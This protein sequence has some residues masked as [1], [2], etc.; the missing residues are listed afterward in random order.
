MMKTE[1]EL[2][3]DQEITGNIWTMQGTEREY[4]AKQAEVHFGL[5]LHCLLA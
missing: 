1:T 2:G 3:G 4:I 5:H